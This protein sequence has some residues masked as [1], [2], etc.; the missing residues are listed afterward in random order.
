MVTVVGTCSI[1]GGAVT[2]PSVWDAVIPPPKTCSECG[3][4]A[5]EHGPVLKMR[6]RRRYGQA[7][8]AYTTNT[9][10]DCGCSEGCKAWDCKNL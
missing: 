2:V 3:A 7:G 6:P 5:A 1:C 8:G 4:E 10:G 9:S